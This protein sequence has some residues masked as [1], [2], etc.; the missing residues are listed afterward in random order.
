M[1]LDRSTM[2]RVVLAAAIAWFFHWGQLA[3]QSYRARDAAEQARFL[4]EERRDWAG[5][6]L[7][8]EDRRAT[9]GEIVRSAC[10][11]FL[12]PLTVLVLV[13]GAWAIRTHPSRR[14]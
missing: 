13:E 12:L 6:Q 8:E 1:I 14:S 7:H 3:Y 4:A 2:R 5:A 9:A 11:G 10:W